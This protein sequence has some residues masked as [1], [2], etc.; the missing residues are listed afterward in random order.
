MSNDRWSNTVELVDEVLA[1]DEDV[2]TKK[3]KL[4]ELKA[5]L[6]KRGLEYLDEKQIKTAQFLG[7]S[8]YALVQKTEKLDMLNHETIK[9]ILKEVTENY[10]TETQEVKYT[11]EKSFKEGLTSMFTNN[12]EKRSVEDILLELG[13][14]GSS[15]TLAL[16]KLKGSW[17]KDKELLESLVDDRNKDI[18]LYLYFVHQAINYKKLTTILESVKEQGQDMTTLIDELKKSVVVDENTKITVKSYCG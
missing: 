8:G 5:E 17:V 12:Y 14:T 18:E 7:A 10:V 2:R 1:L 6:Q 11:F 15:L 13:L 9:G 16:K 3:K 4:D